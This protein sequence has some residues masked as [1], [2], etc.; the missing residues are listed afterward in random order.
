M[1]G[2]FKLGNF[3]LE[4]FIPLELQAFGLS[5]RWPNARLSVQSLHQASAEIASINLI[6][7]VLSLS[8]ALPNT[9]KDKTIRNHLRLHRYSECAVLTAFSLLCSALQRYPTV[10]YPT[11]LA[12]PG[13]LC[14][15]SSTC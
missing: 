6:I 12:T 11:A 14:E 10:H 1:L 9:E 7:F 8:A 5:E 13:K 3:K 4:Y 15:Y 2:S